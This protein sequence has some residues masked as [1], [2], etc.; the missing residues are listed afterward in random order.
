M[1]VEIIVS[2]VGVFIL[3]NGGF[4][5]SVLNVIYRYLVIWYIVKYGVVDIDVVFVFQGMVDDFSVIVI[6]FVCIYQGILG[7]L[8]QFYGIKSN[9]RFKLYCNGKFVIN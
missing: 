3:K 8:L 5:I 9:I 4:V 6:K 2:I 7:I 1:F